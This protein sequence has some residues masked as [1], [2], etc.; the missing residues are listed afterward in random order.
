MTASDSKSR[1]PLNHARRLRVIYFGTYRDEYSRNRIMIE[2]LRQA[3]VEVIECHTPFWVSIE[4][5]VET[6]K[7]KWFSL[8]FLRR[9]VLAYANLV[10]QYLRADDH[11]VVVLGYP[12]QLDVFL[13][14]ILTWIRRKP[15][16]LDVFMS[17]YLI[18]L[19]R[20]LDKANKFNIQLL[21]ALE[22]V[23]LR[24][25]DRLI[26]DTGSYVEWLTK[27][28]HLNYK[29]FRLVPTGADDRIFQ[30]KPVRPPDD[31]FRVIYYGTFIPN[32]RVAYIIDAARLLRDRPEFIFELIGSGPDFSEAAGLIEKYQL[33]DRV[34]LI[35]WLSQ[36]E[37]IERI[38][39]A[40]ACLGAFGFTPQS[41]MTV[42]NKIYE[43]MAM[44]RVVVTGDSPVINMNFENGIHLIT[45]DRAR[46]ETLSEALIGLKENP[47]RAKQIAHQGLLKFRESF[48]IQQLGVQFS[49]HL[50][51]IVDERVSH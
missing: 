39:Q 29:R 15:L 44:E 28:Y 51:D 37:L 47:E 50:C 18:A 13:G 8:S 2:C 3:G 40:D 4:D 14:R 16:V 6:A 45:C 22:S 19:E 10:S 11:E 32:H 23:A 49:R 41:L 26:Q 46:P 31:F 1:I 27:T 48:S 38:A 42:Q 35:G 43:G 17:I 9:M 33:Q 25:P 7:G 36:S 34:K 20:G 5:R 12:G 21:K 30:P 24:L